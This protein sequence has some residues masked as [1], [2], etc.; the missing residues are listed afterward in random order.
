MAT[1][2]KSKGRGA[3]VRAAVLSSA[4]PA[5]VLAVGRA[6]VPAVALPEPVL[7]LARA[8][9]LTHGLL[10]PVLALPFRSPALTATNPAVILLAGAAVPLPAPA[11]AAASV[12]PLTAP[13]CVGAGAS[14]ARTGFRKNR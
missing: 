11:L 6:A 3:G 2:A 9:V 1:Q 7:A 10:A 12:L 5:P 14:F 4:P 13:V 8:A